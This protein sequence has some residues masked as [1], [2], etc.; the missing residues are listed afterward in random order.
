MNRFEWTDAATVHE[1]ISQLNGR[2]VVKAGGVDLLDR[3]KEGLEAPQ[4]LVNIRN[5]RG[6]DRIEEGKDG[7]RIGPLVTLARLSEDKLVLERYTALAQAAGRAATPQIRNMATAGGNL[8]QRPRC[9]YFRQEE[10][11]CRR[12]GGERCFALDGENQYHAIFDNQLCAIVHPSALA[13]P[14]M[15]FGARVVLTGSKGAR[16]V[17]LERFFVTP[18]QDIMREN[19]IAPDELITE[20]KVP[21]LQPATRS[22]YI[23]QGEKESFDWP[24]ADVCAVLQTKGNVC[25]KASI[26]LG[27]AAP[28]PWRAS[29]AEASLAGKVINEQSARE[30]AR[31]SMEGAT[32]LAQNRYKLAVFEAIVRR[33]ILRQ[34]SS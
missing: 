19:I 3:L 22:F 4:R 24:V 25:L 6:L 11:H 27:A 14:L 20:I 7:L 5:I 30:A 18:E 9:W 2:A 1:A 21:R 28:V 29:K 33:A 34:A 13:V 23:K 8:L 32:P 17:E 12:K 31:L 16:E 26:V 10:F 15:A